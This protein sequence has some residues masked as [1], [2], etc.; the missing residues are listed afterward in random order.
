MH[1]DTVHV[2][3]QGPAL[4]PELLQSLTM[5]FVRGTAGTTGSGLGLAIAEAIAEGSGC[6]LVLRSPAGGRHDGFEAELRL[7]IVRSA[8]S[9]CEEADD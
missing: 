2:V 9:T 1:G 4:D 6:S 5:P 7:P 3:N 8:A